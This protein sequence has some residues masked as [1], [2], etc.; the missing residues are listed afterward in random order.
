MCCGNVEVRKMNLDEVRVEM[1]WDIWVYFL[2]D[3]IVFFVYILF[4]LLG[5][6]I[7]IV[8]SYFFGKR[9]VLIIFLCFL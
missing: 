2:D 4:Y 5:K 3:D 9:Y 8:R 1:E 6:I 7:Y